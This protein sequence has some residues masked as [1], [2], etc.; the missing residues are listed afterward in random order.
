ML[1]ITWT[2]FF[3]FPGKKLKWSISSFFF[4]LLLVLSCR[5]PDL[6]HTHTHTE[7][8]TKVRIETKN[9]AGCSFLFRRNSIPVISG[10]FFCFIYI[11]RS[12][13]NYHSSIISS[14]S[15]WSF[16][17]VPVVCWYTEEYEK[18]VIYSCSNDVLLTETGILDSGGRRNRYREGPKNGT[19]VMGRSQEPL[20]YLQRDQVPECYTTNTNIEAK[21]RSDTYK[22]IKC[23]NVIPQTLILKQNEVHMP[24]LEKSYHFRAVISL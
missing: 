19:N 13:M 18:L 17:A 20:W 16:S 10:F 3:F 9:C 2:V 15:K 6:F 7:K 24:H 5:H 21:W 12:D 22:E 1:S 4:L 8:T 14:A 23:L 11:W